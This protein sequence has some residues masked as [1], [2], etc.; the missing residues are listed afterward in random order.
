MHRQG[1]HPNALHH[2]LLAN[3]KRSNTTTCAHSTASTP[4]SSNTYSSGS[5]TSSIP[6]YVNTQA[7]ALAEQLPKAEKRV[8]FKDL[9]MSGRL[10]A[11]TSTVQ[12]PSSS[13]FHL[14]TGGGL[15]ARKL[16]RCD[17]G[18]MSLLER[19]ISF[20]LLL[21]AFFLHFANNSLHRVDA[22]TPSRDSSLYAQPP[23]RR[24]LSQPAREGSLRACRSHESLLSSAHS[25]HMI[26]LNDESLLLPIHQSLFEVP[27]CFRLQST[28]YS[29]RTPVERT[30]WIDNLRKTM[31]PRRDLQ[32][33]T[34]NSLLIWVLEAK[35][36]PAKRK[37]YCEM[38]LDKTLYGRTSGKART[39]NVFWG[40]NFEFVMLPK[41]GEI[42]I[43]LF[44]ESDS[45]KKKDQ[46]IGYVL[47]AIEQLASKCPVERWQNEGKQNSIH[48]TIALSILIAYLLAS[49][50]W[51]IVQEGGLLTLSPS[52][53]YS[54]PASKK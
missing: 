30:K 43:S 50:N 52:H 39:D 53:N 29:C 54:I 10:P 3:K 34:E 51:L 13:S 35:G 47:I 9:D 12:Q 7:M 15:H 28:Y 37:Y 45:K 38:T 36:L 2:L 46:L 6:L 25:T 32:R 1:V 14:R 5:A 49:I 24:H 16:H 11:T 42:C 31:N 17:T 48:E 8:S 22:N 19:P 23:A 21:F 40:E 41:I 18:D 27:N 33:R 4:R 20:F 26:E 44:R